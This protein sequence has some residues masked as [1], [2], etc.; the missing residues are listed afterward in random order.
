MKK[1]AT[2]AKSVQSHDNISIYYEI[3]FIH[4]C[5][6][7]LIF[8]HGL[9]GDLTAWKNE[10]DA[11]RA[12]GYPT[13]ALDLRGHGLSEHPHTE[14]AYHL[15][16]FARDVLTIMEKEKVKKAVIVGHC[17]GGMI[18]L[19]L[20]G[21]HPKTSDSLILVDT[22]YKAPSWGAVFAHHILLTKI[23]NLLANHAPNVGSPGHTD[24]SKYIGSSDFNAY[25]IYH[26]LMNTSLR[27]YF[28]I[29]EQLTQYDATTLLKK[30]L[31]PTLVIEGGKDSIFPPHIAQELS[32]R[33]KTSHMEL[34]PNANHV[35]V[36][37]NPKD[38]VKDIYKF[39]K[40]T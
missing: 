37:N 12:L 23:L 15:D 1:H 8:L 34:I 4:N 25:R 22:S 38:V 35:L 28:L 20:E 36:I 31:I 9:G 32:D 10:R 18:A 19:T 40:K 33:L 11:F 13:L 6:N 14:K 30:I 39:L 24:Y 2:V 27:T 26:D 5:K 17:F 3:D 29:C 7:Y 16:N 21:K